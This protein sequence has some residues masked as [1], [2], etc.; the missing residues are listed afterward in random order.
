MV[1]C[2]CSAPKCGWLKDVCQVLVLTIVWERPDLKPR[3]CL[4]FD[5]SIRVS[6]V[7][8]KESREPH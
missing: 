1:R 4:A 8:M 6:S 3:D 5:E 2:V 7:S